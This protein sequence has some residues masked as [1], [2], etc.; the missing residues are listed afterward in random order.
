MVT[1]VED[2]E[3]FGKMISSDDMPS[4]YDFSIPDKIP[5]PYIGEHDAKNDPIQS[6]QEINIFLDHDDNEIYG[7]VCM[8]TK[9]FNK[10]WIKASN[11][12][13]NNPSN[14]KLLKD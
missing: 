9:N 12:L 13:S 7:L 2:I 5:Q 8:K 11:M 14:C 1:F 3:K 6:I 10:L 4:N